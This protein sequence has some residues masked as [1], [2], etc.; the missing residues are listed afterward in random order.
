MEFLWRRDNIIGDKP[1]LLLRRVCEL[2]LPSSGMGDGGGSEEEYV[3]FD[4]VSSAEHGGFV[5]I[6]ISSDDDDVL[7][8]LGFPS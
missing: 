3:E 4:N 8:L 5:N 7:L 2:R 6:T 1:A